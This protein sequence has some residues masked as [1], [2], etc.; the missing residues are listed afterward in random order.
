M[1]ELKHNAKLCGSVILLT[2]LNLPLANSQTNQ[3]SRFQ[4]ELKKSTEMIQ[5]QR[6]ERAQVSIQQAEKRALEIDAEGER[7]CQA[8]KDEEKVMVGDGRGLVFPLRQFRKASDEEIEAARK[9]YE[10]Q[11]K[12]VHADTERRIREILD[13]GHNAAT[14]VEQSAAHVHKGIRELSPPNSDKVRANVK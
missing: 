11:V 1:R 13:E 8:I 2:V 6:L 3:P 7:R 12:S 9:P 5:K 4:Q 10:E 14:S